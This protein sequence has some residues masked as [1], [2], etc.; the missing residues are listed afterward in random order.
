MIARPDPV[1]ANLIDAFENLWSG[2][3]F[4]PVRLLIHSP[5]TSPAGISVLC[6]YYETVQIKGN[7]KVR[8]PLI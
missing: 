7:L 5:H 8:F 1:S 4:E 3:V 6:S 2:Y